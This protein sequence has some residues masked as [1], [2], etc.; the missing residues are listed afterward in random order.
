MEKQDE[1]RRFESEILGPPPLQMVLMHADE[2]RAKQEA[3]NK[4]RKKKEERAA[5]ERIIG[6]LTKEED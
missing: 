1:T 2:Q 6:H 4:L 5:V 3:L